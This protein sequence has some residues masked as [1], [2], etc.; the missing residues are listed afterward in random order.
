MAEGAK[1]I[2]YTGYCDKI[3]CVD[4]VCTAFVADFHLLI[5]TIAA[6]EAGPPGIPIPANSRNMAFIKFPREIPGI[7]SRV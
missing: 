2:R 1:R 6:S 4:H 5:V 7:F 3:N